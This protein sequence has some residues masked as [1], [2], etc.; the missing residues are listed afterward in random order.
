MKWKAF[1]ALEWSEVVERDRTA[2]RWCSYVDITWVE[3]N[4]YIHIYLYMRYADIMRVTCCL[5]YYGILNHGEFIS[6]LVLPWW[7]EAQWQW[8]CFTWLP[9]LPW[10]H[11]K[12]SIDRSKTQRPF[13]FSKCVVMKGWKAKTRANPIVKA[14]PSTYPKYVGLSC[15][16]HGPWLTGHHRGRILE[17][18]VVMS[19]H[20]PVASRFWKMPLTQEW[21][22]L[23]ANGFIR[24]FIQMR[25]DQVAWNKQLFLSSDEQF[26]YVFL[27]VSKKHRTK[28]LKHAKLKQCHHSHRIVE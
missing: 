22:K 13:S 19:R 20:A 26:S 9:W 17:N 14:L 10:T 23:E 1:N 16:S 15:H 21:K 11:V 28:R 8:F 5:R 18:A 7:I 27:H 25:D 2:I 6:M 3:Y 24:I 4:I 12:T